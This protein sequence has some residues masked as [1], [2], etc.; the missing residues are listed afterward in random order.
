MNQQ[1]EVKASYSQGTD[2][3]PL[4]LKRQ[5]LPLETNASQG[6]SRYFSSVAGLVGKKS[7]GTRSN[8]GAGREFSQVWRWKPKQKPMPNQSIIPP[9][10]K[11]G[12]NR[13]TDACVIRRL[14]GLLCAVL[15]TDNL[16]MWRQP[17][18]ANCTPRIKRLFFLTFASVFNQMNEFGRTVP[19]RQQQHEQLGREFV[20]W[21]DLGCGVVLSVC[22]LPL[23]LLSA[24]KTT[25]DWY[26]QGSL[27][28]AF[29]IRDTFV[30]PSKKHT[31]SFLVSSPPLL[32]NLTKD[33]SNVCVLMKDDTRIDVCGIT[34][35]PNKHS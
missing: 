2:P 8:D 19:L 5:K 14:V 4:L 22:G 1:V 10:R 18:F 6:H 34:K 20:S 29:S 13:W 21:E 26:L 31:P 9:A 24:D 17:S 30:W 7:G 23:L 3:F 15:W 32:W 25:T 33:E 27:L 11:L 35:E 16:I 12:H 28:L